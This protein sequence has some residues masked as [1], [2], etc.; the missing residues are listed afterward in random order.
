MMIKA[1]IG[2][3]ALLLLTAAAPFPNPRIRPF[4]PRSAES[5]VAGWPKYCGTA[6]MGG[7]PTG[8]SALSL[9]T[10]PRLILAWR[11][12]LNGPVAS[13][14]SVFCNTLY[15]GDWG[16]IESAIDVQNGKVLAR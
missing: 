2:G 5:P 1:V 13:A 8:P 3:A 7:T 10:V 14:P 4:R 12:S 6:S 11:S 16:G 15:I 9:G